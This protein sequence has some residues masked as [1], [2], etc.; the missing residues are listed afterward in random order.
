MFRGLGFVAANELPSISHFEVPESLEFVQSNIVHRIFKTNDPRVDSLCVLVTTNDRAFEHSKILDR[1]SR[2]SSPLLPNLQR[3][4]SNECVSTHR[5][6]DILRKSPKL[7]TF[8][9]CKADTWD[10]R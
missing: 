4:G 2:S 10:H 3:L 6:S 9:V 8:S 1:L 5:L 7:R